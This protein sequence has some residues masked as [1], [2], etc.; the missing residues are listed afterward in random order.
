MSIPENQAQSTMRPQIEIREVGVVR[1]IHESIAKVEGLPSVSNGQIVYFGYEGKGMVMG[2]TEKEVLVLMFG[3]KDRVKAGDEVWSRGEPF[4]LPVGEGFMGRIIN[5]LCEP[6]DGKP[7][8]EA[9]TYLPAFRVAPGV[10]ERK[11]VHKALD[12]GIKILD[13]IIPVAMGQRQLLIGDRMTGKTTI[14]IDTILNQKGKDVICIYCCIGRSY[15]N[16]LKVIQVFKEK[17]VFPYTIVVAGVASSPVGEQYLAPY[18]ACALGEYFMQNG[19]NVF[20]AFDDLTKHAWVY[21]QLSLLLQ[22]PPGR[23]A[24]PGDIFYI[25]SQ[26][27]ER[28]GQLSDENGGGSMTFFPICDTLQGDVTGYIQTNLISM[29]DGQTVISA[30]LFNQGVKPAIDFGLSVSRIGNKAQCPAMKEL[31]G[32]L[33]LEYLQYKELVRMTQLRTTLSEEAA[34][35]IRRGEVITELLMQGKHEPASVEEQVLH[36]YALKLGIL[37]PLSNQA[38]RKFRREILGYADREFQFMMSELR[39]NWKLTDTVK[40]QME[41]C[42]RGYFAAQKK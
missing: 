39:Q 42:F 33:R 37:D 38:L 10:M 22:R 30:E 2:F 36:L 41:E 17:N 11:P 12:T 5:P 40:K 19:K 23:E 1:E 16:L 27:V 35:R 15:S 26:L 4:T 14:A 13:A 31:A 8:I 18:T 21:R 24:Y 28:A 7:P 6:C 32:K 29:T 25:H 20:V 34:A 3:G 9:A